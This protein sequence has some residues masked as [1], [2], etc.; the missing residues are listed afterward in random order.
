MERRQFPRLKEGWALDY[1]VMDEG[2]FEG[3]AVSSLT[4]NVSGGGVRLEAQEE[5]Q[6]GSML[7]IELRSPAS[8]SPLHALGRVTWCRERQS[9]G[10]YEVGVEFCWVGWYDA[11]VESKIGTYVEQNL[12]ADA[13]EN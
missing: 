6:P 1:T 3:D 9:G 11:G 12:P 10:S 2:Q 8:E 13:L 7:A 4:V 5:I